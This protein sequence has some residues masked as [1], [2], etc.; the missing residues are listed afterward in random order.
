MHKTRLMVRAGVAVAA[1]VAAVSIAGCAAHTSAPDYDATFAEMMKSSFHD[2][3]IAKVAWLEQDA[4]NAA[5]SK[6]QGAPLPEA[7]AKAIEAQNLQT[8]K[9]PTDGKFI[10]DWEAGDKLAENGR[11]MTWRDKSTSSST[12]GGS[13][14]NCHQIRKSEISFG[15]IGPS[16]AQY[17]KIR[18]V[19]NPADPSSQ[20]VVKYTWAKLWNAKS[21]NAC[22]NMPRFGHAGILNEKQLKDIMALL[23]DPDSP[24]NQ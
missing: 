24:V 11:G 12:N 21:Y 2:K 23:L 15:T 14:Y 20:A 16:L 7:T 8:V 5:C 22:S 4:S 9:W 10:G 1:V 6:A 13:C 3:G 18:G 17:G 19:K